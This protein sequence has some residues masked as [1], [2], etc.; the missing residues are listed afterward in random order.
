MKFILTF[1][2]FTTTFLSAQI[3]TSEPE[4][5]T[6][7]DSIVIYYDATEGDQGL[8]GYTGNSLYAHTGVITNYS[9]HPSDWKHTLTDWTTNLPEAQLT[10]IDTD[11][12]RLVIGFP[13]EYYSM[14]DQNEEI[15]QLAFVFRNSDGSRTGRDVGGADIFYD[16][17][18]P[19][20]SVVLSEPDFSSAQ[21]DFARVS[22]AE[23]ADTV[24]IEAVSVTIGTETDSLNLY[25]DGTLVESSSDNTLSH[26]F[27]ASDFGA[28]VYFCEIVGKDSSGLTDSTFFG[29]AVNP[30]V[31]DLARP[32]GVGDGINYVSDTQVTLSLFAPY[33]TFVYAAGDFSDWRVR[34][35]YFMN[36]EIVN[37]D[38][39][40][41]WVTIDGLTPGEEYSYQ[42][43]VDGE[44]VIADPYTEKVL[45]PW[46]DQEII[47]KGLYRNLKPYPHGKTTEPVS[48]LQT[49][50]SEFD[51]QYTD[52]LD[53][54]ESHNLIIYELLIRDFLDHH[55]YSTLIDT[56]DYL[57]NLGINAIELMP[58][59]EF[60][61][62][63]SWGY[64]TSF[65][66]A[67]DKDY[68]PADDLKRFIDECHRRDIVVILDMVLNHAFGQSPLVRLYWDSANNRPAANNPWFNTVPRHPFNVGYDFNHESEATKA[69]VDRV[70]AYWLTEYQV[71]GFRFDLSK[72]FT[73]FYSGDD[74]E[75][76]GR[77]DASR[78]RLL[79]RMADEIWRVDENAYVI[80][81]HFAEER[82]E[83][84]LSDYGMLSWGNEN[85]QY[86][87]ATMGYHDNYKSDF[88][89]GYYK[90]RGW[91]HPTL[92]TYM[93]SHDEER[94][95]FKNL[96][97]GNGSGTYQ[98]KDLE[99][100]LNRI[101]M[102]AAFFLTFPGPKMIW[103]FGELGYDYSINYPSGM[104]KDRLTPKPIRWDYFE[105]DSRSKLYQTYA[106]LIKLRKSEV[107]FSD[108]EATVELSVT[109]AMKR[110][111]SAHYNLK[112]VIIGNFG[113]TTDGINPQFWSTGTWYDFFSGDSIIVSNTTDEIV[114]EPGEFHIY[115][116]RKLE[117]PPDDILN[118]IDT[119]PTV[120]RK[121]SLSQ[122]YPNPFNPST[123]IEFEIAKSSQVQIKIYDILGR[124]VR[125]LVNNKLAAG[126]Y[127]ILWDGKNQ[128]GISVGSGVFIYEIQA[129]TAGQMVFRQS[130]KMVLIR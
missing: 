53:R 123:T 31:S 27:I 94:L 58:I 89:R 57:Q 103:K 6:Q 95:M 21:G 66:M 67:V 65:H 55:T 77:Y 32:V 12:Y 10:R 54:P 23:L 124:E 56:L 37:E 108:P 99:T 96:T 121:Y 81:E 101:K 122:N 16:L 104:E 98:I 50:Q 46:H 76:M 91:N 110:I 59:N 71:D 4:F 129:K 72:G 14:D 70:N 25:I 106:S 52:S 36:R 26:S 45:D 30:P 118:S 64:N 87:E 73:Q 97:Y 109:P 9:Q 7:N 40:H 68:G 113:V 100:A 19:G 62:N 2:F 86:N 35:S 75:L 29:I 22:F 33:K 82:E 85:H 130:R 80:L 51:W 107:V 120:L 102:A 34:T 119:D 69:Y 41:W 20:I 90:N 60:E 79:K 11:F 43:L 126:R 116:D 61:G 39:V 13:R 5:P 8:M 24:A 44:M 17:F 115:T 63:S 15:L 127:D 47:D 88:Y 42:Y 3:I 114:L 92:V 117:T 93:E 83:I 112:S 78:I 1:L 49:A 28:G 48:I 84:E 111:R 105:D 18:A 128:H 74:V 125:E 38:S